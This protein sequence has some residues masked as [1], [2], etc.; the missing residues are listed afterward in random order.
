MGKRSN[1][2][3]LRSP[4]MVHERRRSRQCLHGNS[5][6][7]LTPSEFPVESFSTVAKPSADPA[8][9]CAP[10][11]PRSASAFASARVRR[12]RFAPDRSQRAC[13]GDHWPAQ[14][15]KLQRDAPRYAQVLLFGEGDRAILQPDSAAFEISQF[16]ADKFERIGRVVR[17]LRAGRPRL[18]PAYGASAARSRRKTHRP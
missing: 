2:G 7:P 17:L 13:S 5:A 4:A 12:R 6:T 14:A 8:Y 16:D 3:D 9:Q 11:S 15:G 10:T 18:R 1:N